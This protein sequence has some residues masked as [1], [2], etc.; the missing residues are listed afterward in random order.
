MRRRR[1]KLTKR[2]IKYIESLPKIYIIC[3]WTKYVIIEVPFAGYKYNKKA[4]RHLP[5]IYN[6]TDN[7][8]LAEE[9]ILK[10]YYLVTSGSIMC[11]TF[12]RS[13]ANLIVKGLNADKENIWS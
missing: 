9:Y 5:Y 3:Q 8:G 10:P 12:S 2:N 7:N 1:L 4:K 11:Y 6:F 13:A